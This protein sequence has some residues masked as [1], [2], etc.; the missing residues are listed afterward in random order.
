MAREGGLTQVAALRGGWAA[1]VQAG[2]PLEGAAVT[3][4]PTPAGEEAAG[5]TATRGSPEAPVTL[6]E[7]ADFQCPY[8]RS[9]ALGVRPRI[10]EAYVETGQVRYV[11]KDFPLPLHANAARAA[12]AAHCAGAQGAYWQMHERLFQLQSQWADQ[13]EGKALET[14]VDYAR[15]LGLDGEAFE[16]CLAS[17]AYGAVVR[18]SVWEGEQVGAEGVPSFVINGQ[19]LAGAYPFET[20][21]EIIEAELAERE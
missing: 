13:R 6:V 1:W 20:F 2:Y 8:C 7:Y 9:H 18:Q 3:P 4:T 16:A 19:L 15:A 10:W 5:E 21:Q 12:E 14:W 11:F 17:G